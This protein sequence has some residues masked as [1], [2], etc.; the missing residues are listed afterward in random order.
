MTHYERVMAVIRHEAPG[1]I[2]C[3]EGFMDGNA[4][5]K[6]LPELSGMEPREATLRIL[7]ALDLSIA[8]VRWEWDPPR[9]MEEGDNYRI[10]ESELGTRRRL[11]LSP[12]FRQYV[13]YPV[14]REEDLDSLT[15]PDPSDA[16]RYERAEQD[17]EFFSQRGYF[18]QGSMGGIFAGVWYNVRQREALLVDMASNPSFAERLISKWG[19]WHLARSEELLKRGVKCIHISED[20]GMTDRPWF[21]PAAYARFY[22]PWHKRLADLCHGYGAYMHMHSHG[23]IMP[24]MDKIV[25]AGVDLL[26]PVGPGDNMDLEEIKRQYGD[27]LVL[28]G[29]ISKY[30]NTMSRTEIEHHIEQVMQIGSRGGGFVVGSEGGVPDTFSQEDFKHYVTTLRRYR[31]EYG[32]RG[33]A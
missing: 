5:D 30:L 9:V 19:E 24:F 22:F 11:Q 32:D 15:F 2:P 6:L 29:G 18:V 27:R 17:I 20:M 23:Y 4:Q 1:V 28:I 13:G 16:R 31:E 21:S 7:E 8:K 3:Y 14:E 25:E 33:K 26:N 10:T 12:W